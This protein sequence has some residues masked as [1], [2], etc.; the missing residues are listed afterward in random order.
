M[1]RVAPVSAK[2]GR[3]MKR[4]IFIG[5]RISAFSA[6]PSFGRTSL[7]AMEAPRFGMK[8]KG[9]AGSMASGVSVGKTCWRK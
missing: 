5:M 8:G 1:K 4:S 7:R 3:R 6:R 2:S 9:W